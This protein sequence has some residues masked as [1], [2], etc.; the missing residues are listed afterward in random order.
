MEE[1]MGI[2]KTYHPDKQACK[3]TFKI[4]KEI[5]KRHKRAYL[6]GDFNNWNTQATPMKKHKND[7]SFTLTVELEKNNEY[8]FRYLLDNEIWL[9]EAEADK[10]V[11]TYFQDAENSVLFV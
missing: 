6:V 9:I 7:G 10:Q 5:A 8:Q 3:V 11:P 4:P 2:K 1:K